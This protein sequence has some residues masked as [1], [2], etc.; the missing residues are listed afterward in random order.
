M[1]IEPHSPGT[2]LSRL[3]EEYEENGF[4]LLRGFYTEHEVSDAV[5]V[6]WEKLPERLDDR[7][8][9]RNKGTRSELAF[10]DRPE[11]WR[12][13]GSENLAKL[14]TQLR[15][16]DRSYWG[17]TT[18]LLLI[19][20]REKA[21]WTGLHLDHYGHGDKILNG[22][23]MTFGMIYLT[24]VEP[25]SARTKVC[26]GSHKIVREHLVSRPDDPRNFVLYDDIEFFDFADPVP[27]HARAGDVLLFDQLL[28]HSGGGHRQDEP[29]L[30]FRLSLHNGVGELSSDAVRLPAQV[31][32][33]L[34]PDQRRLA[35]FE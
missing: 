13:I 17:K 2:D 4:L 20:F 7:V 8:T 1:E 19:S 5:C 15:G 22:E 33:F 28:A 14:V 26:P 10:A 18:G 11:E 21:D 35:D 3:R 34:T 31:T 9:W 23:E 30:V 29:R 27:V 25:E 12:L 32:S 24:D 6:V 16:W